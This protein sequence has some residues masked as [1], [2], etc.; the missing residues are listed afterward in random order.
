MSDVSGCRC[1]ACFAGLPHA[2]P[3]HAVPAVL[4]PV[5]TVELVVAKARESCTA[6]NGDAELCRSGTGPP[7]FAQVPGCAA[8][9]GAGKLIVKPARPA[10][11]QPWQTREAA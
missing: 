7:L 10:P 1:S 4:P 3:L 11:R 6:C 2:R 8:F 5:Q 9:T